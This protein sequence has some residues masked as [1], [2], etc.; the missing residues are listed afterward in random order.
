MKLFVIIGLLSMA[1]AGCSSQKFYTYHLQ[2]LPRTEQGTIYLETTG[3]GKSE[4]DA[5]NNAAKQAFNA[6]LFKGVP[7]SIQPMPM[8]D[9]EAKAIAGHKE[10]IACFSSFNCYS[11]FVLAS[12][13]VGIPQRVKDGLSV[14]LKIK[15]NL[16]TLRAY[17]EENQVIR[18]FGL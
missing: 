18:H 13:K 2:N 14:D 16:R 8:V 7:G 4:D 6:I 10:T 3:L 9:D 15:I 1:A 17:L 5:Y 11:R 12:E